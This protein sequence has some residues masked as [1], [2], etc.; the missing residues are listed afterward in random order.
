MSPQIH[1]FCKFPLKSTTFYGLVFYVPL[2]KYKIQL[3]Y[4]DSL[5]LG[6]DLLE[7]PWIPV[8][9]TM[10]SF[11]HPKSLVSVLT[12]LAV[13]CFDMGWY[14]LQS[15]LSV[16]FQM[17]VKHRHIY[18]KVS[19]YPLICV[20]ILEVSLNFP[21]QREVLGGLRGQSES[22]LR[23]KDGCLNLKSPCN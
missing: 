4:S 22:T 16:W 21:W 17:H 15:A 5:C 11:C 3:C 20:N 2:E 18:L 6:L 23:M 1:V 12:S 8:T 9:I 13:G 10:G 14:C 7:N 19:K